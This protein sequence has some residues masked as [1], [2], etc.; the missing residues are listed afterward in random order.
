MFSKSIIDY[1]LWCSSSAH[2][3]ILRIFN[4]QLGLLETEISIINQ[5][6]SDENKTVSAIISIIISDEVFLFMTFIRDLTQIVKL[7]RESFNQSRF[8]CTT[9]FP[10]VLKLKQLSTFF[11]FLYH[12]SEVFARF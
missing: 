1:F 8:H 9:K 5:C 6:H 12:L 7:C 11:F 4:C 3:Q 2:Y 10:L